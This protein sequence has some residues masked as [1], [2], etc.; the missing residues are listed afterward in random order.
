MRPILNARTPFKAPT[1][2]RSAVTHHD[3]VG[4]VPAGIATQHDAPGA[5]LHEV[6]AL[7]QERVPTVA[8]LFVR[9]GQL[10]FVLVG[11]R[12]VVA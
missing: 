2:A 6:L 10:L 11:A 1:P 8:S 3:L 12:V 7:V 4:P 9:D 5:P